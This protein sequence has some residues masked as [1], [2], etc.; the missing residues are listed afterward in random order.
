M[1]VAELIK[2]LIMFIIY[3][4][5]Y[6]MLWKNVCLNPVMIDVTILL[7]RFPLSLT[8]LSCCVTVTFLINSVISIFDIVNTKFERIHSFYRFII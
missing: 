7:A 4:I 8:N 1:T 2:Q 6:I 3:I 5:F